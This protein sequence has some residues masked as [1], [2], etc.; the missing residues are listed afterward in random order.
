M[1]VKV[2]SPSVALLSVAFHL[3]FWPTPG[4]K[5]VAAFAIS[6]DTIKLLLAVVE[7]EKFCVAAIVLLIVKA[8]APMGE[9]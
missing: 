6:I 1:P 4:V 3:W 9:P 2:S 7:N 5:V 8:V